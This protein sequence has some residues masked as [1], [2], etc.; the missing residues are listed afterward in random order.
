MIRSDTLTGGPAGAFYI[1]RSSV[2]FG[3]NTSFVN[4]SGMGGGESFVRH[5]Y[6]VSA[7]YI[8]TSDIP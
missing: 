1:T 2:T 3:G 6:V 5:A 8:L 7:L 4:S